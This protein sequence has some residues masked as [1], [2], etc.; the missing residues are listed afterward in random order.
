[1]SLYQEV[2]KLV[3]ESIF[4]QLEKEANIEVGLAKQ[5]PLKDFN[6]KESFYRPR[7]V[8]PSL[9]EANF[10]FQEN[11]L[12]LSPFDIVPILFQAKLLKL[13]NT[14][15][16]YRQRI[17]GYTMYSITPDCVAPI[18]WHEKNTDYEILVDKYIGEID[19]SQKTRTLFTKVRSFHF[20]TEKQ[21]SYF[22]ELFQAL[23]LPFSCYLHPSALVEQQKKLEKGLQEYNEHTA[24]IYFSTPSI[25][26]T[27]FG[28]LPYS[29]WHSSSWLKTLLHLVRVAAFIH[30]NQMDHDRSRIEVMPPQEPSFLGSNLEGP[31]CWHDDKKQL[32][33]RAP[34]GDL[35]QSFGYRAVSKMY[36]NERNFPQV[37]E[38]VFE[39]KIFFDRLS[40][41]WSKQ[42]LDEIMPILDLL[43]RVTQSQDL[44]EKILLLYC[45]LEHLFIPK[46]EDKNNDVYIKGGINTLLPELLPWFKNDLYKKRCDYAHKGYVISDEGTLCFIQNSV[47]NVMKLLLSKLK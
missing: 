5:K 22:D 27:T 19:K 44:G 24:R 7:F 34:D 29:Y 17:G 42:V 40:N 15:D 38:F 37:K 47:K 46:G 9:L 6:G 4:G 8:F 16:E 14:E 21:Q 13:A 11:E 26:Y 32:W 33:E 10:I 2:K 30:P 3:G 36:L 23:Q 35:F 45:C 12:T 18:K 1:M 20:E 28:T 41:P 43:T 39:H 25:G 31:F